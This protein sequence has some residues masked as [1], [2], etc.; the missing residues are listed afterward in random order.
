MQDEAEVFARRLHAAGATVTFDGFKGMPH[1][2]AMVPW[3]QAG[4][5]AFQNQA[6]FCRHAAAAAVGPSRASWTDKD[7]RTE[8]VSFEDLG[9]SRD[10]QGHERDVELDDATV[11][12]LLGNQRAWRVKLEREIREKWIEE[13]GGGKE[14]ALNI[15]GK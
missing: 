8:V 1:C 11:D 7:G 3:N 4:R 13:K 6:A 12:R 10:G 9:R 14:R 5:L 15:T 2:F